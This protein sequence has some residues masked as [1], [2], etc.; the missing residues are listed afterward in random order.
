MP[1]SVSPAFAAACAAGTVRPA[2]LVEGYFDSGTVRLWS[3]I[4]ALEWNGATYTGAG[5]ILAI[6]PI[7]ETGRVEAVGTRITLSGL[8][9]DI[10]ALALAE[11][12]QGRIVRIR[13]ALLDENYG[14]LADPDERFTGRADV[15][16]IAED[17]RSCTIALT[18][19]SRLIDLQRPRERR[20][21][22]DDQQSVY[23]GDRGFEFV[24]A[25]QDKQIQ[26]GPKG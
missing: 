25:L 3:G 15:M 8:P 12:Y 5:S 7:E 2:L 17:G 23:P 14:I 11:P 10:L 4:G 16:A 18:V 1:R 21:T 26:W 19:E 20:Y 13:Q 22:H 9:V 24:A 6:D